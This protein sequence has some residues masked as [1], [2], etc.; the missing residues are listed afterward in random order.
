M[1]LV[2]AIAPRVTR[3]YHDSVAVERGPLLFSLKLPQTWKKLAQHSE[4]SADWQ[5]TTDAPWNY[6][7]SL[8]VKDPAASIA[9]R[10]DLIGP[11]P[12]SAEQAPVELTVH[13]RLDPSWSLFEGSAGPLPQSPVELTAPLVPLTLIPYAAA[14]LRVTAFPL[15]AP[16]TQEAGQVRVNAK[17][18]SASQN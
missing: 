6:A 15:L 11:V 17:S 12:F 4:L 1:E 16:E 7:L 3:W 14:K 10:T 18:K 8:D 9:V 2:V 13:G 5:V